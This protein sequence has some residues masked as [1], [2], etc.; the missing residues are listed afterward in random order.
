LSLGKLS[1]DIE[2]ILFTGV[3]TSTF[4]PSIV[5]RENSHFETYTFTGEWHRNISKHGTS[6]NIVKI[7]TNLK[8]DNLQQFRS[9]SDQS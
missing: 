6:S 7:Q 1:Q 3:V 2:I 5:Q 8:E 4:I 9:I